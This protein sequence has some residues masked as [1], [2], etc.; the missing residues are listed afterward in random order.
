MCHPQTEQVAK[1]I[2]R[3]P[4]LQV[5][6]KFESLECQSTINGQTAATTMSGTIVITVAVDN[7][8]IGKSCAIQW[9]A[10]RKGLQTG[11]PSADGIESMMFTYRFME[12]RPGTYHTCDDQDPT[13]MFTNVQESKAGSAHSD[14]GQT[15]YG[16]ARTVDREVMAYTP[17]GRG[18]G[19]LACPEAQLMAGNSVI[20]L[21]DEGPVE[22]LLRWVA[23]IC[24]G[25]DHAVYAC[26]EAQLMAD[27][28]V[29][30]L[31]DGRADRVAPPLIHRLLRA[32]DE[33]TR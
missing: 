1:K 15:R 23:G 31:N 30:H 32:I 4:T 11:T 2:E 13:T 29:I 8:L 33:M 14:K 3:F 9:P 6:K 20:Y 7:S 25:R 24:G 28:P 17:G 10:T 19:A 5:E 22:R 26:P 27:C 12:D 21:N 16:F 18:H